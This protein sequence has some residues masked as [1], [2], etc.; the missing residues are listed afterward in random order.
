MKH[1]TDKL[2][3]PAIA[4]TFGL[5][6][7]LSCVTHPGPAQDECAE[8][9]RLG[10]LDGRYD[11]GTFAGSQ[12]GWRGQPLFSS[13][14][15]Y[16]RQFCRYTWESASAAPPDLDALP[17]PEDSVVGVARDC[18]IVTPQADDSAADDR[19]QELV[20]AAFEARVGRP[21]MPPELDERTV[22]VSL[23]D[24]IPESLVTRGL[25]PHTRHG[26]TLRELIEGLVCDGDRCVA[27]VTNSLG[28]PR[29]DDGHADRERGGYYG[30]LSDLARG[31][32]ESTDTWSKQGYASRLVMVLAVGW[33][34]REQLGPLALLDAPLPQLLTPAAVDSVPVEVQAILAALVH[35]ACKDAIVLAS[36]GNDGAA[37]CEQPGPVGPGFL[38]QRP[39]PSP[40]EC[41]SL[42]FDDSRKDAAGPLLHTV[43]HIAL[44]GGPASNARHGATASL[45]APG[46]AFGTAAGD[47]EMLIGSSVAAA[48]TA[49]TAAWLWSYFPD[50]SGSEVMDIVYESGR[51][52][53]GATS[54]FQLGERPVAAHEISSCGALTLA[55]ERLGGAGCDPP[56]GC[57]EL[58]DSVMAL[59]SHGAG[60]LACSRPSST[61]IT[62]GAD[63]GAS[64]T[65][66]NACEQPTTTWPATSLPATDPASWPWAEPTP[67]VTYCPRCLAVADTDPQHLTAGLA[68]TAELATDDQVLL[69]VRTSLGVHQYPVPAKDLRADR[70]NLVEVYPADPWPD[71]LGVR[72]IHFMRNLR[73][74]LVTRGE[75]LLVLSAT[76]GALDTT[77][78]PLATCGN[79]VVQFPEACDGDMINTNSCTNACKLPI[80]G[81][82]IV[83][84]SKGEQCEDG[85]TSS[86]DQCHACK[87]TRCGDGIVQKPNGN[88]QQESCDD[89]N[90]N[91]QDGCYNSCQIVPG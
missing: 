86:T 90:T 43:S 46:V 31:V 56:P 58:P 60:M 30:S 82:G 64:S 7:A 32:V 21:T 73:G 68:L 70:T 25:T 71:V 74:D 55:C 79:G 62:L 53:S 38:V 34:P 81:D 78:C 49:A 24:T 8:D 59:A 41:A 69:E 35:A 2:P 77:T 28:L 57:A 3:R 47:G 27:E 5:A 45:V 66:M 89:G 29:L 16:L 85:N 80:C 65:A 20:H 1:E 83:T 48:A 37:A 33:E 10:L 50:L 12:G 18:P 54:E 63:F 88:N 13:S 67:P 72:L 14:E 76:D 51:P 23:V 42:G 52:V 39:A 75:P 19:F 87:K 40:E 22:L 61:T 4:C 6:C 44:D 11:C 26:L 84:P 91:N 9:V 17:H 36:A 15:G